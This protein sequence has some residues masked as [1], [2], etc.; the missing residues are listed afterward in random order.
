MC[1]S[2]V[3]PFVSIVIPAFNEEKNIEFCFSAILNLDY[4]KEKIETI[5]VDNGS[6]DDTVK[7]AQK[8]GAKVFIAPKVTI[9]A[10]RNLGWQ[11]S[12][13]EYI[14]FLDSD[15]I[16]NDAWLIKS[17]QNIQLS[18]DIIAVSGVIALESMSDVQPPWVE[19]FWVNYLNSKY[20]KKLTVVKSL[21]SFC[22]VVHRNHLKL[23]DGFNESLITCE[24]SDLGYRLTEIGKIIVD[25]DIKIIHLG[26]ALTLKDFFL[27]Q[28]W[29][30]SSNGRSLWSHK[31]SFDEMPSIAI[32]FLFCSTLLLTGIF[33]FLGY[34]K[35]VLL[36]AVILFCFLLCITMVKKTGKGLRPFIGYFILWGTYLLARGAG[37]IIPFSRRIKRSKNI[38]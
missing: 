16:P 15:C 23:L 7:V 10:L 9:A 8:Y 2:R 13:G 22:F 35:Y 20:S 1:D 6:T 25:S 34:Y 38:V 31:I 37:L 11:K 33:L 3:L 27:R 21:S 17:I 30:G 19:R 24:D 18:P 29:Q 5:V 32:P 26:N 4:P 14:A 36:L 12:E 28:F